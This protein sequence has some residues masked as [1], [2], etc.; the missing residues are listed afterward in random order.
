M[1]KTN[2]KQ[3]SKD[4]RIAIASIIVAGMIV[5]GSTFAWFTSKDEVTNRLTAHADYG[6]SIVEDFTPPE[7][8]TPGQ[9]IN[10]DVSAVNTGNVDAFV[11]LG[12]LYDAKLKVPTTFTA[13]IDSNAT[14]LPTESGLTAVELN[15]TANNGSEQ[16]E[17]ANAV[18]AK[19][20]EVSTLQAGATLVWTPDGAVKPT[21]AQNKSADDTEAYGGAEADEFKPDAS[22]P[23]LYLFR[24]TDKTTDEFKYSG[25]FFDGT[26][27]YAL[28]TE[29]DTVFIAGT[30]VE[31]DGV[32]TD[33][34]D[35][36]LA[37]TK[38]VT[39]ANNV[40]SP[41]FTVDWIVDNTK[42]TTATGNRVDA[43]AETAKY[44]RLTYAGEKNTAADTLDDLVIDVKLA[45]NWSTNWTFKKVDTTSPSLN[46]TNDTGYFYLNSVVKAGK[47]TPML[48]DSVT[49]NKDVTQYAYKDLTF[50]L[51]VVLDSIQI[52]PDEAKT[53]ASYTTGVNGAEWGATA[54]YT[55]DTT[56]SWT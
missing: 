31:D 25:Y 43:G 20:N 24:R 27:Y 55:N 14:E 28:E 9:E 11:R 10:K 12:L 30:V 47:Q 52:T 23:G 49:L 5:A 6:V 36:K 26:K 4:R 48:I 54:A 17:T 42:A 16:N 46:G 33:V 56:V 41:L 18:G 32:V 2:K 37:A 40:D 51:S 45:A 1:T 3:N 29:P 50:D 8:W 39:I 13:A 44:L 7:D 53:A 38:E 21:D 34:S 35:V 19:A 15:T 22:K